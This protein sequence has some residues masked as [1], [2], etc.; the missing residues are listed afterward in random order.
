MARC[1]VL[2]PAPENQHYAKGIEPIPMILPPPEILAAIPV[3]LDADIGTIF[4][5][6]EE[7]NEYLHSHYGFGIEIED[8]VPSRADVIGLREFYNNGSEE[9]KFM[10]DSSWYKRSQFKFGTQ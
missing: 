3:A 1:A 9:D 8:K 6:W 2:P 5:S 10:L 7:V 4:E